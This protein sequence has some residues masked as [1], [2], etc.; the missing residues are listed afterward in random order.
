MWQSSTIPKFAIG[1][2]KLKSDNLDIFPPLKPVKETVFTP[3]FF[4]FLIASI[5]FKLFPETENRNKISSVW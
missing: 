3:S 4:A 1:K 5:K 2:F